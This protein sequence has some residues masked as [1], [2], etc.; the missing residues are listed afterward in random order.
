M[1]LELDKS[2]ETKYH[3][4]NIKNSRQGFKDGDNYEEF[5]KLSNNRI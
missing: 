2:Q 1:C 3:I 5:I 4:N